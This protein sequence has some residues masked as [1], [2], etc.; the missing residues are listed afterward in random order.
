MKANVEKILKRLHSEGEK[1]EQFFQ[2]IPA[3]NWGLTTYTE[4]E[5]WNVQ[6]ILTHLVQAEGG[7]ARLVQGIVSG[8]AGVAEDFDLDAYNQR[9]VDEL[10]TQPV[11]ALIQAFRERRAQTIAMVTAF[12]DADLQ[13]TGRHPFLGI[14][15]VEDILKLMYRHTQLHQ[16]DIRRLLEAHPQD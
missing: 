9:K 13:K 10:Q 5:Q 7:V 1:T 11:P 4:G 14:A 8:G 6:H 2:T 15:P 12:S 16:R 3:E